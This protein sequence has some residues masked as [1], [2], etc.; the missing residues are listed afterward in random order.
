VARVDANSEVRA[1]A[2]SQLWLD[3]GKLHLFDPSDG[4]SMT[5]K[6]DTTPETA[7]A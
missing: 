5:R 4:S 7:P 2:K 1:G 3:V 6:K